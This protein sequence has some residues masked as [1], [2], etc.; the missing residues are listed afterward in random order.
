MAC[1]WPSMRKVI[2]SNLVTL[3]GY[4]EGK[5]RSLEALFEY[6]HPDYESED[7]LDY[8]NTERM[9]AAD[10][11]L[12]SGRD[13]FLGFRD[14]WWNRE[15][16][17]GVTPIR[18]VI[19]QIMNPIDRLVV[20]D[21]LKEEELAPWNNTR[22]VRVADSNKEIAALKEQDGKDLLIMG[23]RT[24]WNDLLVHGLV[25]E[26]HLHADLAGFGHHCCG[27]WSKP[28]QRV[29]LYSSRVVACPV[30]DSKKSAVLISGACGLT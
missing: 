12:F 5:G 29:S 3:D 21:R 15:N 14:Y 19:A 27:L 9:R 24:L 16:K 17:P 8:Y 22:I 10:I 26:L 7:K 1:Q 4:Y 23:G 6:S 11:L 18:K 30:D 28:G 2:V 25:D 20:S 13:S